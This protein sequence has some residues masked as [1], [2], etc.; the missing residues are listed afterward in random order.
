MG[1]AL[2]A[3]KLGIKVRLFLLD[4]WLRPRRPWNM[5]RLGTYYG[6]WWIPEGDPS[7]GCALCVGAGLD[8]SFDLE[9][10]RL[11][12]D[13][14][15]VDPTPAA[16]EFVTS[17]APSLRLV[18][19][20]V[21]DQDGWLSFRQDARFPE[22]W[23]PELTPTGEASDHGES[24]EVL[25]IKGL[26]ARLGDPDVAILKLDVEGAEHRVIRSMLADGIRPR[27]VCVEFDANGTR[28]VLG[29]TR[30]LR[31]NG[32]T[33]Y[34]LENLNFTFVRSDVEEDLSSP[35]QV[36]RQAIVARAQETPG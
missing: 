36:A 14:V 6:G 24:F 21:W 25:T 4:L 22:S 34:Q 5:L 26:L 20:G 9:L 23:Y 19:V 27:T 32:Y 10:Q 2:L 30:L 16:V 15:T 1:I 35:D 17:R 29:T 8:V 12:Y 31:R 18:P 7:D 11:G 13:V 33:L 28:E 3:R